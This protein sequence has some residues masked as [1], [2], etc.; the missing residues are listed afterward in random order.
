MTDTSRAV[1]PRLGGPVIGYAG[2]MVSVLLVFTVSTL[3]G[4]RSQP[5]IIP[6]YDDWVQSAGYVLA[7]GAAVWRVIR[8]ADQ[9]LLWSVVALA[10][11]LRAFGFLHTIFILERAPVYPSLADVGW[12]LSALVLLGALLLAAHGHLP[13]HSRVLALDALLG[14]LTAAAV[15]TVLLH[16]TLLQL[17]GS[18]IPADVVATNLAYPLLDVALLVVVV[19]LLVSTRGRLPLATAALCLGVVVF[20][21]VDSVFLYQVAAGTFRPGSL[22]TPLSLAGSMLLGVAGWLPSRQQRPLRRDSPGLV[23]P[24][25]L[26]LVCVAVLVR[27]AVTSVPALGILLAAAGVVTGI[28][29]GYLTF[30]VDQRVTRVEMAAKDEEIMRFRALVE[31]SDD[32]IAIATVEG[33][34]V[35]LNPAGRRLVGLPD[36][37]DVTT[38][39]VG[40]YVPAL[41]RTSLSGGRPGLMKRGTW[42]GDSE[43]IDRRGG[44]TI[45]VTANTFLLRD[46]DTGEAWLMATVQ[47]DISELR[48]AEAALRDL[49]EERKILLQ[50]LV[51][52]QEDER[53][54]IAAD[55][56]DDSVQALATVE[57]QLGLLRRRLAGA[58]SDVLDTVES[59]HQAVRGAT[60]RLRHLLFDLD[61][62][63]Q[64][65]DL[66]TAVEEAAATLFDSSVRWQ[67]DA[68]L[69]VD[70]PVAQRVMAYRMAKE[71]MVNIRKHARA[72]TVSIS[73]RRVGEGVEVGVV[74]DG[75]GFDGDTLDSRPG[76]R[77]LSDMRD[78]ATIA[79]GRIEIESRPGGGTRVRLWLPTSVDPA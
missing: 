36:D 31:A 77:G 5:G 21:V 8:H 25:V 76:H 63:A 37:L 40:D 44:P 38:T 10:L 41:S 74:D 58:E 57:V 50:H 4:V 7:T 1:A 46:P 69:G 72:T 56:H 71:A 23:T 3:P 18:R 29:R 42:H 75:V 79:G 22:L 32:F 54:R 35:Y 48:A 12:V 39:V 43:L 11:G 26:S 53:A 51:E 9:R 2:L 66:R 19:G 47:R 70:L 61:S 16:K 59:L 73:V 28:V 64:R 62:P 60:D 34:L 17:S 78:R 55:V 68:E 24:V 15:S 49:A 45:P 33:R 52:A 30:A 13:R 20:A 27:D 67:V 6:F 14:G 65:S